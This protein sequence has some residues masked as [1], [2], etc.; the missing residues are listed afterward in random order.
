MSESLTIELQ[1]DIEVGM[2]RL[3]FNNQMWAWCII[4]LRFFMLQFMVIVGFGCKGHVAWDEC[5]R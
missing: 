1:L 2:R 4:S 3:N 5:Q